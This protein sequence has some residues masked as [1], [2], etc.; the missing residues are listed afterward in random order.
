[1]K[2]SITVDTSALERR[3][4]HLQREIT[5]AIADGLT[6]GAREVEHAVQHEIRDSVDRPRPF[7]ERATYLVAAKPSRLTAEVGLKRIQA[8][9][10]RPLILGGSRGQK[11]S[12][13]RLGGRY[14][15]PG[16]GV[17][18]DRYGNV[19]R[20]TLTAILRAARKG[21]KYRGGS[22]VVGVPP[23]TD[24]EAGVWLKTK[25]DFRPLLLIVDSAPSYQPTVDFYGVAD[26]TAR[27]VVGDRI[28]ARVRAAVART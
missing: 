5:R 9:Y 3:L 17:P 1:M 4:P 21:G 19:S 27:R 6:D 28:R 2:L 15:V 22:I 12:E 23:G 16:P 13:E 20:G 26:R 14:Y 18:V 24:R 25:R 11:R 7:T 8:G 10:L